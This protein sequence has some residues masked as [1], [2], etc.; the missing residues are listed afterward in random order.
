VDRLTGEVIWK[1]GGTETARSL[2]V[3]G[4]PERVPLSAQHDARI[5][6][7]GT[8]TVFDNRTDRRAG[9]RAVRY[10]IDER[11]GTAT[12]LEERRDPEVPR[13]KCCG[14]ARVLANGSWLV[15]WGGEEVTEFAPDGE[16]AFRLR[17][18]GTYT[19]RAI[20]V[21]QGAVSIGELR[22]GM[23]RMAARSGRRG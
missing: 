16:I 8:L 20:P 13:S 14:S 2:Q 12:F 22:A 10:R 18:P 15:G 1:L 23:D 11:A 19:Y 21:P 6:N 17:F 3:I 9:P 7:D 5:L 4:D